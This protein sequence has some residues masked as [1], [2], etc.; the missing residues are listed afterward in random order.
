MTAPVSGIADLFL[1][2][3]ERGVVIV[4]RLEGPPGDRRL[5]VGAGLPESA[6]ALMIA[7]GATTIFNRPYGGWQEEWDPYE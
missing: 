1:G 6:Q 7:L 4:L 3:L 2:I 5:L